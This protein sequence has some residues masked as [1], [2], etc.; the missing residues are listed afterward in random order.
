MRAWLRRGLG[1]SVR[2]APGLWLASRVPLDV[3]DD[4]CRELLPM[5]KA[6]ERRLGPDGGASLYGSRRKGQWRGR[7]FW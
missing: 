1:G 3:F 6:R 7:R 4:E 5:V 2:G